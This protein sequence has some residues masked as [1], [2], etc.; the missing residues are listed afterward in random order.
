MLALLVAAAAG[1]VTTAASG[2]DTKTYYL[3][4]DN[5]FGLTTGSEVKVA[6][7]S[8]GTIKSLQI[9]SDKRAVG[10]RWR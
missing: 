9:N 5:A 8:Q 6:G 1:F 7:V 10:S 4:F 3:E 2:D